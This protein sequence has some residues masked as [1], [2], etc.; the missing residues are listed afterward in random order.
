[1]K[2]K[3]ESSPSLALKGFVNGQNIEFSFVDNTTQQ[4]LTFCRD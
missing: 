3:I 1:M 4:I 2:N